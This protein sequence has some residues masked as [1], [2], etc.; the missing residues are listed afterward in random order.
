[1]LAS[2]AD[3]AIA[4]FVRALP[5][6][7]PQFAQWWFTVETL[8]ALAVQVQNELN[9][10]SVLVLGAPSLAFGMAVN[11]ADVT[12]FDADL[13]AVELLKQEGID[14]RLLDLAE[15]RVGDAV[16]RTFEMAVIDPPW[17]RAWYRVFLEQVEAVLA[18]KA[19]VYTS[20]MP[21][22]HSRAGDRLAIVRSL[23]A[24]DFDIDDI[25]PG[26]MVYTVP[27]GLSHE[28]GR[29]ETLAGD[30]L[31][32]RAPGRRNRRRSFAELSERPQPKPEVRVFA[33][34]P[35]RFRLFARSNVPQRPSSDWTGPIRPVAFLPGH[36]VDGRERPD[37]WTSD[38]RGIQVR[39]R[40]ALATVTGWLRAWASG[41]SRGELEAGCGEPALLAEFD[42]HLGLWPPGAVRAG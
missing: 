17:H 31:L 13:H 12:T 2:V 19:R 26:R 39:D 42:R 21:A 3:G 35:A 40:G 1:M 34:T 11:G 16:D 5:A 33:R 37:V 27:P 22:G 14:A 15:D 20:L 30:L 18:P 8:G 6:P 4:A 32:A 25:E 36:E 23:Q 10:G 29:V 28:P 9:E 7:N 38:R 41:E 24:A